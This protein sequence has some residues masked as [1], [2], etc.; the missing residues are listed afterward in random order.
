[1]QL[2]LQSTK[3]WLATEVVDFRRSIN[4]LSAIVM[5]ALNGEPIGD[6]IFIF[7]NRGRDKLKILGW[8]R[9]GYVLLYK[10]LEHGKFIV[11]KS[12]EGYLTISPQ[13]FSWLLAGLDWCKMS[14]WNDELTFENYY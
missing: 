10:R 12:A 13:Q 6:N 1:M 11:Q 2:T 8:H 3:I 4:G 5:E 7:Y 9:N 14:Y